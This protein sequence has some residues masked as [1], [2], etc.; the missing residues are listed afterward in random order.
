MTT[1]PKMQ[2]WLQ[3]IALTLGLLLGVVL[4]IKAHG[5]PLPITFGVG[6]VFLVGIAIGVLL[7]RGDR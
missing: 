1:T 7:E 4:I 5:D 2:R 6:L 3:P